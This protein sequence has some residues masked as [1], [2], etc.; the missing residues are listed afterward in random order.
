[1]RTGLP[2]FAA[3]AAVCF[4]LPDAAPALAQA[5]AALA[6]QVSSAQEGAMEGVVVS[7]KKAGGTIT[8]SVVSDAKGHYSFPARRIE[9]GQYAL[10]IRAIGY[11]LDGPKTADVAARA[12]ATPAT[13][14]APATAA[15][16]DITLRPAKKLALQMSNAEWL[17]SFPGTDEQKKATLG[18]ISCHDLDRIAG[19]QHTADAST[20][21]PAARS[22][23]A[24]ARARSPSSTPR[25]I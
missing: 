8:V 11:E 21:T 9:P 3:V 20:A 15:T 14:A 2:I 4:T 16:A 6:G 25:S 13:P 17:L 7:A 12:P 18:C 1:M 24:P 10:A 19:S 23:R 5:P 22:A